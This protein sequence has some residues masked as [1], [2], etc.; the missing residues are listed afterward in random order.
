MESCRPVHSR[1]AVGL[2]RIV[3]DGF[4]GNCNR[5]YAAATSMGCRRCLS[6]GN[7]D[8]GLRPM[9]RRYTP[10]EG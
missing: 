2:T 10:G 6:G 3:H 5:R 4:N 8:E 9:S 7:K 1:P